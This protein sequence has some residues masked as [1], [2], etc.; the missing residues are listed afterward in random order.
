LIDMGVDP[1][2]IAPTLVLAIAQRLS[3]VICPGSQKPMPIDEGT[4]IMIDKQFADLPEEYRTKLPIKDI[5]HEAVPSNECP[6]GTRGRIAVFEMFK[7]DHEMQ[8]VILKNPTEPE[9]YKLARQKGMLT[10]KEDA[11]LKSAQ[12][13]IPLQEV[14]NFE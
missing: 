5:L 12:G 6:S 2:L 14:Y 13:V 7:V 8:N 10:M 4:K 11:I 3:R 9:I 1:Y